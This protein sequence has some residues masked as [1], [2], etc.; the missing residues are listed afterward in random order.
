MRKSRQSTLAIRPVLTWLVRDSPLAVEQAHRF[1][2]AYFRVYHV[3]VSLA[4]EI[5]LLPD[6][7][8]TVPLQYPLVHEATYRVSDLLSQTR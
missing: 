6:S 1:I 7:R 4:D 8:A 2:D 5:R 3:Q